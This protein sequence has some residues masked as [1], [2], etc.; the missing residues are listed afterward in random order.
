M[1]GVHDLCGNVWE[2]FRGLRL[3]NGEL[4]IVYNNDAAMDIDLSSKSNLWIPVE[5]GDEKVFV[6]ATDGKIK[7]T[8]VEP[9]EEAYDGCCWGDVKFDFEMPDRF[10]ELALF[11]GEPEAY[12][13]ADTDGERL[14][15]CG[16]GWSGT[17]SAGVFYVGLGYPR[18]H[19][20]AS[21]GFRSAYYCKRKP[22]AL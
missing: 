3:I 2:W 18:S 21:I 12:I 19:S 16:G 6:D 8:T 5:I 17:G 14:P 22:V 11:S 15:L 7:F 1:F 9:S 13:Y 4:Q 20:F 10:K